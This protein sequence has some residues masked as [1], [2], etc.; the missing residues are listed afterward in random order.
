MLADL[1]LS[2]TLTLPWSVNICWQEKRNYHWQLLK[3][4]HRW[5]NQLLLSRD[6]VSCFNPNKRKREKLMQAKD[7]KDFKVPIKRN[8]L[9]QGKASWHR[10]RQQEE[11]VS[12]IQPLISTSIK[13]IEQQSYIFNHVRAR[14]RSHLKKRPKKRKRRRQIWLN[15]KQ[16]TWQMKWCVI[17][18]IFQTWTSRF[19]ERARSLKWTNLACQLNLR[20]WK[21]R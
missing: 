7:F 10:M 6:K 1:P 20:W 4:V 12:C 2:M 19:S 18:T 11:T 9:A 14:K 21:R 8:T 13:T 5:G 17:S 3:E 15:R 16:L